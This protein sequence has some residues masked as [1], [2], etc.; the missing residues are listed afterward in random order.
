MNGCTV[1][2]RPYRHNHVQ[3]CSELACVKSQEVPFCR[4]R[5]I[6]TEIAHFPQGHFGGIFKPSLAWLPR[7]RRQGAWNTQC[8]G[9]RRYPDRPLFTVFLRS[10]NLLQYQVVAYNMKEEKSSPNFQATLL[11]Y[12]HQIWFQNTSWWGFLITCPPSKVRMPWS[13]EC[14][15]GIGVPQGQLLCIGARKWFQHWLLDIADV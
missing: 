5:F 6:R 15:F 3:F 12:D 10:N 14:L 2:Y 11:S 8:A 7:S 9:K 4:I 1:Q 13:T